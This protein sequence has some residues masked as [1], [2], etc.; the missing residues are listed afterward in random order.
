MVLSRGIYA[1]ML[2]KIDKANKDLRE[3]THQNIRLEP[4]RRRRRAKRLLADF[5]LIR[6]YATSLYKV[7]VAG[8]SWTC[9]CKSHH[10]ASLRL[11][12]RPRRLNDCCEGD[13]SKVKFRI[14]LSKSKP[15]DE[16]YIYSEWRELEVEPVEI[17][18]SQSHSGLSNT[19]HNSNSPK[20]SE[21]PLQQR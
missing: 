21:R 13:I 14:L 3:Y 16:P 20:L 12:P 2:D 6:R 15:G 17:D 8:Q 19:P 11:E 18:T 4:T 5:K 10:T 1:E 7:I 9:G